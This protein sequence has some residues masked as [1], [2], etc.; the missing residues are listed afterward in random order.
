MSTQ[1][2]TKLSLHDVRTDLVDPF[3]VL[4]WAADRYAGRIAVSTSMGP[5]TLVILHMLHELGQ[6]V[7]VF[8]LDTGLHF[9]ETYA[10]RLRI[11]ARFGIH[12]QAV[13]PKH[14]VSE[15]ADLDGEAL[16]QQDPDRC[17]ALRKV[18]PLEKALGGLS[19]WV[20]GL[21]SDQSKSRATVRPVE[22]DLGRGLVKVNPLANWS[23]REVFAWLR[24]H[25]IPYNPLLDDGFPSVG[26]RPCTSRSVA[27]DE[28]GGR[29]AG[30]A[31]T[32]CGI[33][34]LY[35]NIKETA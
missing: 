10:L 19:A 24:T 18:D 2:K 25:E 12:I 1:P 17:C 30:R 11:Q 4:S 31:K 28:R 29:W 20:T 8:F 32:E 13:S 15:Q 21:R 16:W 6:E 35:S 26:C 33:H 23:R 34:H 22:W 9:P 5:Q 3:E 14:T 7:P 27:G